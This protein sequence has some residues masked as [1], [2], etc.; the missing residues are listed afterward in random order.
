MKRF[1][2]FILGIVNLTFANA[3]ELTV[4]TTGVRCN[5]EII[6][7]III[8]ISNT[9]EEPLWIWIDNTLD[10]DSLAIKKYL[11]GRRTPSS[12]SI[13]E[14]AVDPNMY[15]YWWKVPTS[16]DLFVKV[17][18]PGSS[19]SFLLFKESK[20]IKTSDKDI[21]QFFKISNNRRL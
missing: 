9:E 11:K 15:G 4:D 21:I 2:C 19:F 18:K 1:I 6:H 7:Q 16:I 10:H 17:L 14:I 3:F 8:S 5:N 12:F 13:F 20:E